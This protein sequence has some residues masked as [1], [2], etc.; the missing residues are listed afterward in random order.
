MAAKGIKYVNIAQGEVNLLKSDVE[1]YGGAIKILKNKGMKPSP[2]LLD[3]YN[4]AQSRLNEHARP[5]TMGTAGRWMLGVGGAILIGA[6]ILKG[7]QLW[8][9]Y[10]RT[11][12]PIPTM[13]VDESDI[14]TYL[15]DDNGK[16][17]LDES[18]NQ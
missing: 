5:S 14:V 11:M 17:L 8:K 18:G 1:T 4:S 2:D 10:E 13:I 15:T 3:R 7:V 16:P 9:Y 6:A 12:K